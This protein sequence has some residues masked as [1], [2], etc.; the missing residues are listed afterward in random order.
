MDL[1]SP[2]SELRLELTFELFTQSGPGLFELALSMTVGSGRVWK[3]S[4]HPAGIEPS[5]ID[6]VV[7]N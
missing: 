6:R 4:Q 7:E 3:P 2:V 1:D 5:R